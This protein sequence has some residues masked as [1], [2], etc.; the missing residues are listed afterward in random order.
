[1]IVAKDTFLGGELLSRLRQKLAIHI[2]DSSRIIPHKAV[3]NLKEKE[4]DKQR[5]C[6]LSCFIRGP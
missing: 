5:E 6:R 1:M 2:V 4:K 3:H